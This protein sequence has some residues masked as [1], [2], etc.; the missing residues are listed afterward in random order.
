M[1]SQ[2]RMRVTRALQESENHKNGL[3][4]EERSNIKSAQVFKLQTAQDFL[5]CFNLSENIF[6]KLTFNILDDPLT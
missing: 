2:P 3:V 4:T 1:N 5:S 6:L